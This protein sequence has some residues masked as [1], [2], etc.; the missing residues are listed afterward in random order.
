[1]SNDDCLCSAFAKSGG[2][3]AGF[4]FT[5]ISQ[6]GVDLPEDASD[7]DCV[8]DNRTGYVWEVKDNYNS[9]RRESLHDADDGFT[10]YN[11]DTSTSGRTIGYEDHGTLCFGYT[12]DDPAT[13]C[14]PEAF[15]TRVNSEALCGFED[16]RVPNVSEL[17]SIVD[18]GSVGPAIDSKYFPNTAFEYDNADYWTSQPFAQAGDYAWYINFYSGS[19]EYFSNKTSEFHSVRLVR[20]D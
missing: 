12:S 20:G 10:W 8:R 13:F 16:R 6:N 3:N 19:K 15:A 2:G 14:N 1:M 11:S 9:V 7:W 4:D 5:K 18:Y 17:L